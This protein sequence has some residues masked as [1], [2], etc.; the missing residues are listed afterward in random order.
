MKRHAFSIFLFVVIAVVGYAIYL[1]LQPIPPSS[2]SQSGSDSDVPTPTQKILP[3]IS[4]HG[5]QYNYAYFQVSDAANLSLV[6]NFS[7]KLPAATIATRH[8]CASG[9]NGG[10]YDT[11]DAPL[12][13]F[14]VNGEKQSAA[15]QSELFN[16]FFSIDTQGT[17]RISSVAPTAGRLALQTGPLLYMDG[18]P[19]PLRIQNDEHDR[20]IG[21]AI[22][23]KGTVL[24]FSFFKQEAQFTGPLLSEMPLA[25]VALSQNENIDIQ[26]ALNLDGGSAS[27]YF[28]GTTSLSELRPVGSMFCLKK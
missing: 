26:E 10:F 19:L 8:Q 2:I 14:I 28:D 11:S 3:S 23:A 17:P 25:V 6:P 24:F 20:R 22:T 4:I 9:I 12:G 5:D 27:S 15:I 21:V 1:F 13:L 7:D 18:K 16:G